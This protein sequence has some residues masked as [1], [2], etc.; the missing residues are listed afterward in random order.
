MDVT[1]ISIAATAATVGAMLVSASLAFRAAAAQPR[2]RARLVPVLI[3]AA[4]STLAVLIA[5]NVLVAP[6]WD[7][8][9]AISNLAALT[10][11]VI[12]LGLLVARPKPDRSEELLQGL[13]TAR[14]AMELGESE[15]ATKTIERLLDDHHLIDPSQQPTHVRVAPG[16]FVRVRSSQR[17]AMR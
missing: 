4:L 16:A 13:L 15:W 3:S 8:A 17:T 5:L 12:V 14:L 9:I 7:P 11:S 10:F 2:G 6:R 1:A